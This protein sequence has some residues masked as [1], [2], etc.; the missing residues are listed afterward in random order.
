MGC[1]T[2]KIEKGVG[3]LWFAPTPIDGWGSRRHHIVPCKPIERPPIDDTQ[4]GPGKKELEIDGSYFTPWMNR[5]FRRETFRSTVAQ[6]THVRNLR[7]KREL[8]KSNINYEL[9]V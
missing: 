5:F 6:K 2:D 8:F 7:H 9:A 4:V 1:N 3:K